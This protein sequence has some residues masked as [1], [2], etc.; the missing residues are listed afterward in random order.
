[1][2]TLAFAQIAWSVAFQW[3]E[4]TGGSERDR[5]RVA[6][7]LAREQGPRTTGSRWRWW[8]PH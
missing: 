2:L 5:R 4:V 6:S 3:D 8:R 7:I 1:M